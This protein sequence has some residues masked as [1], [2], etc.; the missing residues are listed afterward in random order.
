MR[1]LVA[2]AA[3][4]AVLSSVG[5]GGVSA[6]AADTVA[7]S[8]ADVSRVAGLDRYDTAAR[9]ARRGWDPDGTRSWAGVEHV[10]I[11]NG[12]PGQEAD[13]IAAAGLA[14]AY[15]APILLTQAA[16]LPA[17][18]RS[19][20]SEIAK[21]NPGV[22]VHVIGGT[23]AVPDA[24][25]RDIRAIP[26][27]GSTKDR[28]SGADRYAT[29]AAI[30]EEIV[31][32]RGVDAVQGLILIAGDNPGAYY[33]ALAASPIAYANTMP[34]LAVR[35]Y[36]VPATVGRVLGSPELAGKPRYA[37]SGTTYIAEESL[38][39]ATRMTRSPNR[40]FAAH[41]I[42]EFALEQ[43]WVG[44]ADTGVVA[45][46]PD[47]L[48]GG[49]FLGR[50]G[51]VMLFTNSSS[52]LHFATSSFLSANRDAI[53]SG[54]I[55]GGTKAIPVAQERGFR[56]PDALP[57]DPTTVFV[58][59]DST[60]EGKRLPDFRDNWPYKLLRRLSPTT[61]MIVDHFSISASPTAIVWPNVYTSGQWVC[62]N[63]GVGSSGVGIAPWWKPGR[64]MRDRYQADIGSRIKAGDTLIVYGG[65]NDIRW[66]RS[67]DDIMADIAWFKEQA[68]AAG[69]SF[70]VCT[71]TPF[72]AETS[73][74]RT[75]R[76]AT[77]S[78]IRSTYTQ[79]ADFSAARPELERDGSHYTPA[80]CDTLS[81]TFKLEW[82][83]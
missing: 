80:G 19:I 50:R 20:L 71:I 15:Q 23:K 16:R 32:I 25:W 69:A 18:T 68:D 9:L 2:C 49:T 33:D 7:M 59:G 45:T 65:M 75:V 82:L 67:K 54:W 28:V 13:P 14:G 27:I 57:H 70:V 62:Y 5:L 31:R 79:V 56:N 24:R 38:S 39:D 47:A 42:A 36:S 34:M 37:A 61:P 83:R 4:V 52:T 35:L 73:E 10:I 72:A 63:D 77:N 53:A 66:G 17:R 1:W 78:A 74:M 11:A 40:S 81:R 12:E 6:H 55:I 22:S 8:A 26:G 43:G 46:L 60:T 58:T 44:V 48:T 64:G 3:V 51:G 41:D 21:A 29:S 30:A 76:F